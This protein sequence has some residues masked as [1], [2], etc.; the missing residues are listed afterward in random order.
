MLLQRGQKFWVP[1]STQTLQ[2]EVLKGANKFIVIY[3]VTGGIENCC[4]E[5]STVPKTKESFNS[6]L[7]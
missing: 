6:R 5:K 7:G 1:E 3:L 2:I 4:S